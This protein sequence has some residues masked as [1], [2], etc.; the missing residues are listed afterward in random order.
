[1]LT[2]S[3]GLIHLAKGSPKNIQKL[4]IRPCQGSQSCKF[5]NKTEA[6]KISVA[7]NDSIECQLVLAFPAIR[8][9]KFPAKY[10]IWNSFSEEQLCCMLLIMCRFCPCYV[11]S[12]Q[13]ECLFK[14]GLGHSWSNLV[15]EIRNNFIFGVLYF[16]QNSC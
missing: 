3:H 6:Q 9:K 15:F 1:M 10:V 16:G 14:T 8:R 11:K 5:D 4:L 2:N 13:I 7:T 12:L